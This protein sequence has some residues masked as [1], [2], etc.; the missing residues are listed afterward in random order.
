MPWC[1]FFN[2][3][4]DKRFPIKVGKRDTYLSLA[5]DITNLFDIRNIRAV[6]PVTG[7]PDDNGY[8]SDPES[9][10]AIERQLDPDSYRDLYS[11]AY[12][13]NYFYYSTPRRFMATIAYSF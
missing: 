7:N 9:Q 1:F 8:L 11:I 2:V 13:N 12:S 3:V 10:A 5:L 6:F 4:I